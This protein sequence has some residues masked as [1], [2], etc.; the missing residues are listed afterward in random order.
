MKF[1]VYFGTNLVTSSRELRDLAR[2]LVGL[3][4]GFVLEASDSEL[5]AILNQHGHRIAAPE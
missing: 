3:S 2:R 5:T 1:P 4:I